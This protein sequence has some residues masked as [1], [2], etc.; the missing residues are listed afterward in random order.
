[1]TKYD[2]RLRRKALTKG[3]IERHKN[4]NGLYSDKSTNAYQ[5]WFKVIAIIAAV[6][7]LVGMVIFGVVRL[8][9]DKTS[10]AGEESSSDIFDE[11]KTE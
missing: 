5:G 10:P 7:L 8:S 4:F 1:M 6:I 9:E 2:I 11:F 3:Q